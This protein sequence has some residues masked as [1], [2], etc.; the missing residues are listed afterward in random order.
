MG[1]LLVV[2]GQ[3]SVASEKT[4]SFPSSCLGTKIGGEALLRSDAVCLHSINAAADHNISELL[5][6]NI[7]D[8]V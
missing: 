2:S 1:H 4:L 5:K 3:W 7:N 6:P 8:D